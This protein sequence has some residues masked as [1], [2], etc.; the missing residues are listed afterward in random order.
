MKVL[1]TVLMIIL[2]ILPAHKLNAQEVQDMNIDKVIHK[3]FYNIK[4]GSTN[5]KKVVSPNSQVYL[6]D[7]LILYAMSDSIRMTASYT[8]KGL[9][10]QILA[11]VWFNGYWVNYERRIWTYF[12]PLTESNLTLKQIWS[13]GQWQNSELDS[14]TYDT[15]GHML[16]HL[17]KYWYQGAWK[18]SILSSRTYDSNGNMLTNEGWYMI[19]NQ[20]TNHD[21]KTYT[22][23]SDGNL[24]TYLFELWAVQWVNEDLYTYTYD[25]NGHLLTILHQAWDGY[26][27]NATLS[28]YTYDANG[29]MLSYLF[30]ISANGQWTNSTLDTY[31]ND[32]NGKM[33]TDLLKGWTNGVW[34]NGSLYT[35]TYDT[36]GNMNNKLIQY[37]LN[38]LWTNF[39]QTT[40][41]YDSNGNLI[42]GNNTIWTG[43]SWVQ[44]DNSF[45]VPISS[46]DYYFTGYR[47]NI[48]YI[49]LNISAVSTDLNNV[50]IGYSLA[51]NYPNPFN[52]STK[53]SWQLPVGSQAILKVYNILGR[54]V[55]TLVNE[56]KPAGK[57][58]TEFSTEALPSGVY[59]YQLRAGEYV[60]TKKMI[61]LK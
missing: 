2:L 52:P 31:T 43:S 14:S 38:G 53:I 10:D 48:S 35:Y 29:Y 45:V 30:Q 27:S 42:T 33:L 9:S 7:T 37:W 12:D 59:F 28:T 22:Y 44:F 57:Y 21:R 47:I 46:S 34:M 26:W 51:Q 50:V 18:D 16:V 5:F 54:E 39:Y 58:E 1:F 49:L 25:V 55:A 61:L 15:Q 56:Y 4:P 17:Y 8:Q 60:T 20:W 24:L 23:D 11:Q 13:N 32:E 41:T 36:D 3:S 40:Y 6:P 19:N